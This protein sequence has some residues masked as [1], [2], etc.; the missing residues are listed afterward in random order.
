MTRRWVLGIDIGGTG[1]RATLTNGDRT[2]SLSGD[3]A[4]VAGTGSSIPDI[5]AGL[6]RSSA[7]RWPVEWSALAAVGVGA[8]GAATLV[9]DPTG[10]VD[11]LAALSA[12]AS[13]ALATDAVTT[14]LGALWHR[15]DGWGHLLGDRGAGAWI[16]IAGLRAATL[17][18]DGV[19]NAGRRLLDRARIRFGDPLGWPAQL[20]TRED[21]AGVLAEFAPDVAILSA[22]G[23]ARATRILNHAGVHVA[24]T[25]A[26]AFVPGIPAVASTSG[27]VFHAGG[28]F[29]AAFLARLTSLRPD[30][31]LHDPLGTSLD[32]A[33]HLAR[34][35]EQ[36]STITPREQHLWLSG[37]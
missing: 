33:V 2:L 32:G 9:G 25:L 28:A 4:H 6:M 1:S 35:V 29:T 31:E 17:A 7:E 37:R 8:T 30:V 11:R 23:D 13:V 26:A 36:P 22:D 24:N 5:A 19:D 3:R 16:G 14:H 15:V 10:A 12:G 20:Y 34:M 27:G 18:L 21:R